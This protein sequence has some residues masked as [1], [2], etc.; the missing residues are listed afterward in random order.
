MKGQIENGTKDALEKIAKAAEK[1]GLK[2]NSISKSGSVAMR[3]S[4]T[5]TRFGNVGSETRIAI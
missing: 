1:K 5:G 3:N 2:S 4:P